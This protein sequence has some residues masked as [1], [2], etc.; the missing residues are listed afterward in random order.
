MMTDVKDWVRLE[1]R[2]DASIAMVWRMWTEPTLF[3]AWYGPKGF[4]VPVAEMDLEIGG[5]RKICMEMQTPDRTMTMWFTGVFKEIS[6]PHR[7][8]YTESMC[9]PDGNILTPQAMGMPPGTPD[10]TEVIVD[11]SE[12]GGQTVMVMIHVGVPAGS[13][14]EGGWSQAFEKLAETLAET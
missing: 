10:I 1:R 8:R 14:G 2:F 11:L 6:A 3:S 13:A 12:D 4:S 7:L 5:T 9:D